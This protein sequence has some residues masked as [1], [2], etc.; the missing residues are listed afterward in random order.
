[1]QLHGPS[2]PPPLPGSFTP[3]SVRTG[4]ERS[5][6]DALGP[7]PC[8]PFHPWV[9]AAARVLQSQPVFWR[10]LTLPDPGLRPP[11]ACCSNSGVYAHQGRGC[12][13]ILL[14]ERV[15]PSFKVSAGPLSTVEPSLPASA[16]IFLSS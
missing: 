4:G 1:M 14:L 13:D 2:P 7:E 12:W 15:N 16:K 9:T 5:G 8:Q 10:G 11:V 3:A 6:C